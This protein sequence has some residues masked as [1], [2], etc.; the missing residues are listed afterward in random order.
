VAARYV[1]LGPLGF[2]GMGMVYKAHDRRTGDSVA[3]KVLRPDT[4]MAT[5][6][7]KRFLQEGRLASLVDHPQV[8]RIHECGEDE[9]LHFIAMELVDGSDLKHELAERAFSGEEAY[10]VALQ[11]AEGLHAIHLVG[12]VHRDLKTPNIML[13][14]RHEVKLMDFGLA[15]EWAAGGGLTATGQCLGTPEYMSP[16]Q[17]RGELVDGRSDLYALGIVV[18]ELFTGDVPFYGDSPLATLLKHVHEAPPLEGPRAVRLPAELRP[19]LQSLLAKHPSERPASAAAVA[20]MLR[21]A[22][23]LF[24]PDTIPTVIT[25]R[26]RARVRPAP[27]EAVVAS[28]VPPLTEARLLVPS[29]LRALKHADRDI[30]AGGAQALGQL[31]SAGAAA[32]GALAEALRDPEP[33]VRLQAARALGSIGPAAASARQ[34]LAALCTD[35]DPLVRGAVLRALDQ[36]GPEPPRVGSPLRAVSAEL[37][38]PGTALELRARPGTLQRMRVAW[39][40]LPAAAILGAMLLLVSRSDDPPLSPLA[41]AVAPP[42]VAAHQDFLDLDKRLRRLEQVAAAQRAALA[43]LEDEE[44]ALSE[45]RHRLADERE[46]L[47]ERQERLAA[48]A[49]ARP[50]PVAPPLARP[51]PSP[52]AMVSLSDLAVVGPVG[53][54]TPP[55]PYPPFALRRGIEGP[56]E[57]S[58]MV[59]EW[60]GVARA[61]WV[62]GRSELKDETLRHLQRWKYRPAEKE[63]VPVK[64]VL[65][66]RLNFR[67]PR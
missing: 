22:Q 62:S 19:V 50:V 59:D 30:R 58:L 5:D 57:V 40:V 65:P 21:A 27:S 14:S 63:G 2:G 36:L 56:V 42:V 38:R 12:V 43:A 20:E 16:E 31:G 55:P 1:V 37:V 34:S 64:V 49:S 67:I 4:G 33:A 61:T 52:G 24:D 6:L 44:E 15:K 18:F 54:R 60:G 51:R 41:A 25:S 35:P 47:Q 3:L 23:A 13:S 46:A 32:V 29:L 53:I 39:P 8:C 10:G 17:V 11:I 9:G 28:P 7:T 66:V 48:E 26:P 45:E